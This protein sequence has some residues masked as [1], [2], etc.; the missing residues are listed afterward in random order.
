MLLPTM[1]DLRTNETC[2]TGAVENRTYRVGLNAV[3]LKTAPTGLPFGRRCFQL[4]RVN[5]GD[6]PVRLKTAPTGGRKRLFI[7]GIHHRCLY[8]VGFNI[9]PIV[10]Y[11][12]SWLLGDDDIA[13]SVYWVINGFQIRRGLF[14]INTRT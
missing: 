10:F 6:Y 4:R 1:V 9:V 7:F 13:F 14:I 5:Y 12:Q 11:T 3:R 8:A 2:Q